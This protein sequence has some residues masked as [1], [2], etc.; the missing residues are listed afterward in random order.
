MSNHRFRSYEQVSHWLSTQIAI[1]MSH[2]SDKHVDIIARAQEI[3]KSQ[4]SIIDEMKRE[5][6]MLNMQI[7]KK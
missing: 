7:N 5:I 2:G 1:A 6:C 3:I 4:A